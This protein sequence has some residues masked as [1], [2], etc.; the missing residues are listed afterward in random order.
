MMQLATPHAH[1]APAQLPY[2]APSDLAAQ[3]RQRHIALMGYGD[4]VVELVAGSNRA[5]DPDKIDLV[6]IT[7]ESYGTGAPHTRSWL[8]SADLDA[9]GDKADALADRWGNVYISVGTYGKAPNPYKNGRLQ[10]SRTAPRPR[11]C[12]VADDVTD[13][14][15]LPL[16]PTWATETSPKNYQIGYVCDDLLTPAQGVKLSEGLTLRMG[17]DPSGTDAQ[18]LIRTAGSLNTKPKCAGRAGNPAEGV[19]PEGW[20][21]RLRREGPRYSMERLARALLP[22]GL[23]DLRGTGDTGNDRAQREP[24]EGASPYDVTAWAGLPDGAALMATSRYGYWFAHREQLAQLANGERVTL[25]IDGRPDDT[26]HAQVSVL[27]KNLVTTGRFSAG[28]FVPGLGAPPLSEIRAVALHWRLRLRPGRSLSHY[29]R[30]VDR[31]IA[32]YIP[33]GYAPEATRSAGA[34][35]TASALPQL[36]P[37]Q[38]KA[39]GRPAGQR[40]DRAALLATLLAARIGA[41]VTRGELAT[42]LGLKLRTVGYL[43]ADLLASGQAELCRTGHGLRVV[44]CAINSLSPDVQLIPPPTPEYRAVTPNADVQAPVYTLPPLAP[45]CSAPAAPTRESS[46]AECVAVPAPA[47]DPALDPPLALAALALPLDNRAWLRLCK[48]APIPPLAPVAPFTD[49]APAGPGATFDPDAPAF[50]PSALDNWA[51]LVEYWRTH[52]DASDAPRSPRAVPESLP[53]TATAADT[54]PD[55]AAELAAAEQAARSLKRDAVLG[56]GTWWQYH[57]AA[58]AVKGLSARMGRQRDAGLAVM[59]ALSPVPPP[60]E[61]DTFHQAA[62]FHQGAACA[63]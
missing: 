27:V 1:H 51:L 44:R 43:L 46:G 5:S 11:R 56:R 12:I 57:A 59:L 42:L 20:R 36:A 17:A 18:Q 63:D 26:D 54:A 25:T 61:L 16:P 48:D 50:T 21:V 49:D 60:A 45:P 3:E 38:H 4:G 35:R 33:A 7:K 30:D 13:L 23:A 29:Q 39:P 14:D 41:L 32:R 9:L 2:A 6:V 24:G 47:L 52:V 19:A 31:L 28:D 62:L 10:Y 37:A 58:R 53:F 55:L 34:A 40:V 8:P 15:A 22:G